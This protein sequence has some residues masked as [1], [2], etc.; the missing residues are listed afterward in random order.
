MVSKLAIFVREIGHFYFTR[1]SKETTY[2]SYNDFAMVVNDYIYYSNNIRIKEKT[3]WTSPVQY[4]LK[5][6]H[7]G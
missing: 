3:N 7:N 6:V 5:L 4:R 2:K 1:I